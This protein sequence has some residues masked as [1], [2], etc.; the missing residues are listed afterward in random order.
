MKNTN[1]IEKGSAKNPAGPSVK[2]VALLVLLVILFFADLV[3]GPVR[4]PMGDL[5]SVLLG[6]ESGSWHT[7]VTDFRLPRVLTAL[8]AGISLSVSGLQMQTLFRNPLAGPYVLGISSGASL[9]VAIMVL[10]FSSF[11]HIGSLLGGSWALVSAA[12]LGSL[13]VLALILF[14][15]SRVKDIMTVLILGIMFSSAI[16]AVVS[17]MQYFSNESMLKSF[18]IWTMGSLGNLTWD[19]LSVMMVTSFTGIVLGIIAIK[20]LDALLLGEEYARSMGMNIISSRLLIFI[21]TSVLAGGVTAFCGPIAFIGIAAPHITRLILK[22]STHKFL[23]PGTMITGAGILLV[24]D[25][26]SQLPGS[27]RILPV[28]SVTALIGIPVLVWIIITRN[29]IIAINQ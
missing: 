26:I 23:L 4:V 3:T 24:S 17:I 11:F 25:I 10:G 15:S 9:G 2:I 14:V 20:P 21:S 1:D 29:R 22:R 19:Q 6:S 5:F 16:S 27:D 18:V 12:W 28:N 8:L 13:L 7:I